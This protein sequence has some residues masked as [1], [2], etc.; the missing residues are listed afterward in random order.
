MFLQ[1]LEHSDRGDTDRE[2]TRR[3]FTAAG[4]AFLTSPKL[5]LSR[6]ESGPQRPP[7]S[8]AA[9]VRELLAKFPGM[10]EIVDKYTWPGLPPRAPVDPTPSFRSL[11][12][13]QTVHVV[14]RPGELQR[15]CGKDARACYI[16]DLRSRRA[17]LYLPDFESFSRSVTKESYIPKWMGDPF[18]SRPE[19]PSGIIPSGTTET[20]ILYAATATHEYAHLNGGS[21]VIASASQFDFLQ[22]Y[23][24][25]RRTTVDDPYRYVLQRYDL[26]TYVASVMHTRPPARLRELLPGGKVF[27]RLVSELLDWGESLRQEDLKRVAALNLKD[28]S[29][30]VTRAVE[31]G[32][33]RYFQVYVPHQVLT[34]T[35]DVPSFSAA[36][37]LQWWRT[38]A[39]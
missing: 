34:L 6:L 35:G 10:R 14:S 2:L 12:I 22:L 8:E 16:L 13:S 26:A 33:R 38:Q 30:E 27:R 36:R 1:S 5:L 32:V 9:K 29:T 25:C 18:V 37:F 7:T 20:E 23:G 19:I 17:A 4:L 31:A 15:L 39:K 11:F 24:L 3:E 28:H 21:E